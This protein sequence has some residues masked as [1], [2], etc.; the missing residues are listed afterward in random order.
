MPPWKT[1]AALSAILLFGSGCANAGP[2][3]TEPSFCKVYRPHSLPLAAQE[4]MTAVE[5]EA[6]EDNLIAYEALCG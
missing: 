3:K 2:A 1:C 5:V 4:V 6:W